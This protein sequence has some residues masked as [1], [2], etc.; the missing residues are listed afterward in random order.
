[1]QGFSTGDIVPLACIRALR[2]FRK[3]DLRSKLILTVHDSIVIDCYPGELDQIKKIL[4]EAMQN[5]TE[6]I[7]SRYNYDFCIP[8]PIEISQGKNWLE[9]DEITLV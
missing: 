4:V 7:K 9:Q 5:V 6:E 2:L 1:M 3:A 8:L